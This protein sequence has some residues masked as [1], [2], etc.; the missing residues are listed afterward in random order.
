MNTK[1]DLIITIH[2]R[3]GLLQKILKSVLIEL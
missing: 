3:Y 1:V 2:N